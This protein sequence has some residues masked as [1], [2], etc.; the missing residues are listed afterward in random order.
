MFLRH[1]LQ[2]VSPQVREIAIVPGDHQTSGDPAQI[3]N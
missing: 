3:L 1:V 2:A